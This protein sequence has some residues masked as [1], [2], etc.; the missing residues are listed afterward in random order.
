VG[1][2]SIFQFTVVVGNAVSAENEDVK[3]EKS[4]PAF[5]FDAISIDKNYRAR[6]L[7]AEDFPVNQEVVSGFLESFGFT[8]HIVKNGRLAIR[9]LEEEHYDLVL[10]DVQMPEMDGLEATRVIR[11]PDSKVLNHDIGIIALT[12]HA[13]KG[14]RQRY[15]DVGMNDYLSKPID[16]E[17]LYNVVIKNL[18]PSAGT[19]HTLH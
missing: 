11:N 10:M 4:G 2:G 9:A 1:K 13:L 12:G 18:P 14:D 6:I 3:I 15:L 19:S 7:V 5:S 16:P 17:A 8:A